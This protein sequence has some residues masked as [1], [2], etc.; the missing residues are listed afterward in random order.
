MSLNVKKD[1]LASYD[2]EQTEQPA[3]S[4]TTTDP[5]TSWRYFQSHSARQD[6]GEL[7]PPVE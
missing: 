6:P 1:V 5:P 2:F 7:P 4:Q 3:K